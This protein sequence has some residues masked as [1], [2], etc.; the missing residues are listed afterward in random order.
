MMLMPIPA[1]S[2]AAAAVCF[3]ADVVQSKSR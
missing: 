1:C 3:H 2:H